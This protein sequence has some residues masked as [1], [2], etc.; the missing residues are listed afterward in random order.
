MARAVDGVVGYQDLAL[1][2]IVSKL[3]WR[4]RDM[5]EAVRYLQRIA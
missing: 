5:K 1:Y 3:R 2:L 4:N